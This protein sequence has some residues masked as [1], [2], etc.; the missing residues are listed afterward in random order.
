MKKAHREKIE[1]YL[2]GLALQH[3]PAHFHIGAITF[4]EKERK[5]VQAK[6][7]EEGLDII[8]LPTGHPD[9]TLK[10]IVE[11]VLAEK[12]IAINVGDEL[13]AKVFNFLSIIKENVIDVHLE[14]DTESTQVNPVPTGGAIVL[15]MNEETYEQSIWLDILATMCYIG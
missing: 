1:D 9:L 8:D 2:S 11:A 10:K 13:P 15:L 5:N 3:D 7:T 6:V 12:V 4:A 14:G